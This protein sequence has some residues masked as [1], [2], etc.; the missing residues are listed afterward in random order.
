MHFL[1]SI[2]NIFHSIGNFFGGGDDA[3]K[4]RQEQ[5]Q[6]AAAPVKVTQPSDASSNPTVQSTQP[7]L[8]TMLHL[9]QAPQKVN[10]NPAPATPAPATPPP[11]TPTA[12]TPPTIAHPVVA[13]PSMPSSAIT[14]ITPLAKAKP[15]VEVPS[16][17][18]PDESKILTGINLGAAKFGTQAV[19]G[20]AQTPSLLTKGANWVAQH[21]FGSNAL[22]GANKA[23]Q[24]VT[25]QVNKPFDATSGQIDKLTK[26]VGPQ[27]QQAAGMTNLGLNAGTLADGGVGLLNKAKGLTSLAKAA[28]TAR[29]T[30]ELA[31]EGA[32]AAGSPA[33]TQAANEIA[34]GVKSTNPAPVEAPPVEPQPSV[35][36]QAPAAPTV[37]V[38]QE[39]LDVPTFQR[40]N[41]DQLVKD[42]QARLEQTNTLTPPVYNQATRVA[43]QNELAAAMA[44]NPAE[45]AQVLRKQLLQKAAADSPHAG[46]EAQ[47]AIEQARQKAA[48]D[49]Q[50][51]QQAQQARDLLAGHTPTVEPAPIPPVEKTAAE[52]AAT[53]PPP[54]TPAVVEAAKAE[55]IPVPEVHPNGSL[56]GDTRHVQFPSQDRIAEYRAAKTEANANNSGYVSG[57]SDIVVRDSDGNELL[58]IPYDE[59]VA[60]WGTDNPQELAHKLVNGDVAAPAGGYVKKVDKN[61][62]VD[63]TLPDARMAGA[64]KTGEIGQSQG[65]F[66]KGSE[67]EKTSQEAANQRGANEAANTSYDQLKQKISD[68]GAVTTADRDTAK[69]LLSRFDR[70]SPEYKDLSKLIGGYHTEAAQVLSTIEKD[71]RMTADPKALTDRFAQ[72]LYSTADNVNVSDSDFSA[73][74]QKNQA[75]TDARDAYNQAIEDFNNDPS[76]ANTSKF[77]DSMK[78]MESA[79]RAAKF[80]EYQLADR[81]TKGNNDPKVTEFVNKLKGDAGVYTMD[82][83]DSSLLSST[84]V[85]LN[86]F[87]NTVGVRAEESM[88]GKAGAALARKL[89]G[90]DIGG[91]SHQGAKL[92]LDLGTDR[93]KADANLR[94]AASGNPLVKSLKNVVTTGNTLGERNIYASAY[95]GVY[96]HYAAQLKSAGYTGEELQRRALVNSLIDPDKIANDYMNQS[97]ADNAMASMSGHNR[98]KIETTLA[99]RLGEKLGNSTAARTAAKAVMRITLGFPTVVGRSLV[100][101]AKRTLLGAPS[102]VQAI[103]NAVRGGDPAVTAK[104]IK[105]SVKE[106]GSG[107]TLV[108][109]GTAL[110]AAGLISGAYPT[111]KD[112]QAQWQRE[113]KTENSINIGGSWYSLP[114]SLGVFALPFLLGAN[115][116]SNMKD[117]NAPT[118]NIGQST[119]QTVVSSMPIDSLTNSLDFVSNLSKGDSKAVQKY[120]AA[121]GSSATKMATPVG[122]FVAEVAKMFDPTANDTTTGDGLAQFIHKVM[123]GI[124]GASNSVPDKIVDGNTIANPNPAEIALGAQTKEQ[125]AGVQRTADLQSQMDS[126]A[127]ELSDSGALSD[128]VRNVLDDKTKGIFDQVKKGKQVQPADMQTLLKGMTKNVDASKDTRFLSDGN[129]DANLAV[130]KAKRT[131]LAADPTTPQSDLDAYDQQIKRGQVAKDNQVPYSTIK[132]YHDTSLSEWRDMGD[133]NSDTYDP[134]LYQALWNYDGELANADASSNK[135]SASQR[136]YFAKGVGKGKGGGS[137]L[138][139]DNT[140]GSMPKLQGFSLADLAPQ[141]I[142][143]AQMPVIQKVQPGDLIKKRA[144][145][146]SK[147]R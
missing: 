105:N 71:A 113:G 23:V 80:E 14:P 146:V 70:T 129:Y 65:K 28:N 137:S 120:L 41:A 85:M 72:K 16:F 24:G 45:A 2:G 126:T 117:G 123:T 136:F 115:A 76:A 96:D 94:Q 140:I 116:G 142:A 125:P 39:P 132:A 33:V 101:G 3:E 44:R 49:L 43:N 66:A 122:S 60:K 103:S 78:Q 93:L 121:A 95:S 21:L 135:T 134:G 84:R 40:N 112:E 8:N 99:D 127:K 100:G 75:F 20:I 145:S 139:K 131:L 30:N 82:Y 79:D 55:G 26:A 19:Q 59:A 104:L 67:Y 53:T 86:N 37:P 106:A 62:V 29:V 25:D 143:N 34:P 38:P 13:Q 130:L 111:N 11:P 15:T 4:K 7:N 57:K 119:V 68:Q 114:S 51:A 54:V 10:P 56:S 35:A 83:V 109:I 22:A 61:G 17:M 46:D 133:P 102:A 36:P 6:Q 27:A 63:Y 9:Y 90:V 58:R 77:I 144:I 32:E 98:T 124:P 74:E 47:A 31:V 52:V 64:A 141:K 18:Q 118:N 108:G 69:A 138:V 110:G 91:G 5:Q 92:G 107:A 87:L 73:L 89:T 12:P 97:L 42:A 88:F 128:A 147:V 81:L 1:T 48:N 50:I